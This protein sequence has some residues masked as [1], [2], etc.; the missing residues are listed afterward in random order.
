MGATGSMATGTG[1]S[2]IEFTGYTKEAAS[3]SLL[4][5]MNF[6]SARGCAGRE[7]PSGDLVKCMLELERGCYQPPK[8]ISQAMP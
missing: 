5:R 7:L 3:L 1:D 6:D 8:P 4:C 2:L